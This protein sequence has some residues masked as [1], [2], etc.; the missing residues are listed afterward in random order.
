MLRDMTFTELRA[1]YQP[2]PKLRAIGVGEFLALDLPPRKIFLSP[3]LPEQ[4]LVM[5]YGPRGVGKTQLSTGI[6]WALAS[7]GDFLKWHADHPV[8]IV[9]VDGEMPASVLQRRLAQNAASSDKEPAAPLLIVTP[10]LQSAGVPD[11]STEEGQAELDALITPEIKVV[12]LDNLSCLM[13]SGKENEA[14]SWSPVQTWVLRHRAEGRSFVLMHH[15]GKG[16]AQRGTSRREDVLDVVIRLSRPP[17]YNPQDGAVFTVTY[18]KARG[19]AGPDVEGFE[20]A[21]TVTPDG[22]QTWAIRSIEDSTLETV[23]DLLNEGLPQSEIAR[24]LGVNRSTV[25]R[26]AKRARQEG[27][28]KEHIP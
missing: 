25:C 7:G 22:R 9:L 18:E 11:L 13:R 19:L 6:A 2:A 5:I 17:E 14:E 28:L 3:F 15:A 24:E 23:A 20:A 12:I 16:G 26:A 21:L 27:L 8:G 1:K 10:D 4:G